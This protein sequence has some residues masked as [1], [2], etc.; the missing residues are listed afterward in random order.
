MNSEAIGG[1]AASEESGEGDSEN[2]D[3]KEESE[4]VKVVTTDESEDGDGRWEKEETGH[5]RIRTIG[6]ALRE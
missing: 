4:K 2:S 3:S 6:D 1:V 5:K